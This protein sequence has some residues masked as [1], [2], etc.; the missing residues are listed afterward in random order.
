MSGGGGGSHLCE[1]ECEEY[2]ACVLNFLNPRGAVGSLVVVARRKLAI[3]R[4]HPGGQSMHF[5]PR[6]ETS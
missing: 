2:A 5:L 3:P 1:E 6:D 4:T